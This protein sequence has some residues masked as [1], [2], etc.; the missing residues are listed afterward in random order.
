MNVRT[1][2][3]IALLLVATALTSVGAETALAQQDSAFVH[4]VYR[5]DIP[6][7]EFMPMWREGWPW[8]DEHGQRVRYAYEGMPL[9]GYLYAYVRNTSNAPI[10]VK[11]FEINGVSIVEGLPYHTDEEVTGEQ[12]AIASLEFSKLPADQ[13]A[14]LEAAGEPVWWKAE[15][16]EVAPGEVC[17]IVIRLRRDPRTNTVRVTV[18]T[19]G[20]TRLEGTVNVRR[21]QPQFMSIGFSPE[22]D[23]VYAYLRHPSGQGVAPNRILINGQDVTARATIKADRDVGIVPVIIP[24]QEP[25]AQA[26]YNVFQADY[27]D[28]T[29]AMTRLGTW[30]M[31]FPYGMWGYINRGATPEE[32]RDY[33]INDMLLHNINLLMYSLPR[34]AMVYLNTDEGAAFA[35]SV[36][37]NA[38]STSVHGRHRNTLFYFLTDEPDA[39]DYVSTMLDPYKRLGGRGQ[40][41]VQ[42]HHLFRDQDPDRPTLLNINNTF[43]PENWYMYA[44]LPDIACADPYYQ[45]GV[46]SV[47]QNDPGNMA[48]Y[49]KPTYVYGAGKIYQSAAAPKPMHLILHTCRFDFPEDRTPYRAPT[50]E[51]KR[52]EVYYALATGA[53]QLSYW[54]YTPYGEYYGVGGDAPEMIDLWTEI[55]LLGAEVRTVGE[56]FQWACPVELAIEAPHWVWTRSLVVGDDTLILLVVNDN[57]FSDRLGTVIRPIENATLDV[58]LPSW[59]EAADVFEMTYE[60]TKD[61]DSASEGRSLNVDLG[62]VEVTRMILVTKRPELRAE[63]Q[64]RYDD[65]FADNVRKLM[66]IER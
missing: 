64:K 15:P 55:G 52:I 12:V 40:Y 3:L 37:L 61:I 57:H 7:P 44:Q 6:F 36:G 19:A 21:R 9:G 28:G 4:G 66:A 39:A 35:R 58:T 45:E 8:V 54:W 22:L 38:M 13:I 46:Q 53:K 47:L 5:P 30:Y 10:E 62:T 26:S 20:E 18:P 65:N 32:R 34:D 29:Q 56:L 17:E 42:R 41:L 50:A 16:R 25:F 43:K 14:R 31:D 59:M 63:L 2:G 24:L 60:G 27:A 51:E 48:G 1:K 11:D 23:T 33:Y 49:L